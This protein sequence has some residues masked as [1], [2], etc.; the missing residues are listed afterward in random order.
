M[1]YIFQHDTKYLTHALQ[2]WFNFPYKKM[3]LSTKKTRYIDAN[4]LVL[5]SAFP[6]PGPRSIGLRPRKASGG[7]CCSVCHSLNYRRD[8]ASVDG[9]CKYEFRLDALSKCLEISKGWEEK[10]WERWSIITV[11][12]TVKLFPCIRISPRWQE[13]H[14]SMRGWQR[15][16][17]DVT[18]VLGPLADTL[19]RFCWLLLR[20]RQD[21]TWYKPD[22][23]QVKSCEQ[24][25]SI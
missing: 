15:L 18:F 14:S 20:A 21:E 13:G 4:P 7:R 10:T 11:A 24:V 5:I 25:H 23:K 19:L 9:L 1:N 12:H 16:K 8:L 2:F 6:Y 17:E 3:S 22:V